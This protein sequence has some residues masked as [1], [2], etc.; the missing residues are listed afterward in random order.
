[1][2]LVDV[3]RDELQTYAQDLSRIASTLN[4]AVERMDKLKFGTVKAH[5]AIMES[6]TLPRASKFASDV[7]RATIETGLSVATGRP[8]QMERDI[9]RAKKQKQAAQTKQ[10]QGKKK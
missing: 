3:S 4:E 5:K 6:E 7:L 9:A 10:Q 8:T 2:A 1:M